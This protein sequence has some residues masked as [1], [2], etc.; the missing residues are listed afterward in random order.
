MFPK[1]LMHSVLYGCDVVFVL[2]QKKNTCLKKTQ[3]FYTEFEN[4]NSK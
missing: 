2:N 1:S 4:K 3:F